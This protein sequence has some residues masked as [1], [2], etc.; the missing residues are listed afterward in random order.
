MSN[1]S[2]TLFRFLFSL[3][4]IAPFAVQAQVGHTTITF[5]D[6][7][8]TG[9]FGSGGGPGRQIQTEIYYPADENG[10]DVAVSDG[11][12]PVVV[13]GHGFVMSWEAYENVWE[14]LVS[15]GYVVCFP[16][17]EGNFSPDHEDFG[18]D[19][20]LVADRMLEENTINSS[21]F[22]ESLMDK[23][24]I[25]GHSMGGGASFIG[26][27]TIAVD[28]VV[29]LA[30]AETNP[31]AVAAAGNVMAPLLMLSGGGDGVTPPEDHQIPIYNATASLCKYHVTITGGGHC[32]FANSNF[33]CDTGELFAGGDITIEREEQQ[34]TA[35]DYI[36]PWLDRWLKGD[37]MAYQN[38]VDLTLNDDRTTFV[39]NCVVLGIENTAVEKLIA[40]PNPVIDNLQFTGEL[41]NS[42][43]SIVIFNLR[44]EWILQ[45]SIGARRQLSVK[46][47]APGLYSVI[48]H[49]KDG[50]TRNLKIVK[51]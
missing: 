46:H 14:A 22:F 8:R 43:D 3:L 15:Q 45:K 50:S 36:V 34:E 39:E 18:L 37:A 44:G 19:L 17:T 7:D 38:F 49:L 30:S 24:A 16:R 28:A 10:D 41:A 48:V 25:M 1:Q 12:Y 40:F 21:L 9:G 42:V 33:N 31:S 32:Y 2:F 29:G 47:L 35:M 6:P 11:A 27:A 51:D 4:L 5:N 23:R 26:A 13:F 20:A